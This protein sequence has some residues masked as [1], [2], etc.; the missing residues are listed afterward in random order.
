MKVASYVSKDKLLDVGTIFLCIEG[1]VLGKARL[2]TI[3][4][5]KGLLLAVHVQVLIL[6]QQHC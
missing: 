3:L 4:T 1:L 2:R 5:A 6:A